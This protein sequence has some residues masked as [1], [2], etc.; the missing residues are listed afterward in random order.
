MKTEFG[1]VGADNLIWEDVITDD[2][3][4]QSNTIK[5]KC[6]VEVSLVYKLVIKV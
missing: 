4:Q 6:E 2:E 1:N 5:D 3:T